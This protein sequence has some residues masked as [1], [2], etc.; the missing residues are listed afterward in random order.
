MVFQQFHLWPHMTVLD[1]LTLA[2]IKVL[3]T[4]KATAINNAMQLLERFELTHKANAM[5]NTLSGGQQQRISIARSLMMNPKIMLLD[6]P[7]SALDPTMT[8]EILKIIT[9]LKQDKM[10]ILISTHEV[11]FA[12]N[13]AD[14]VNF[15]HHGKIL[16]QGTTANLVQPETPELRQ[17]L[18]TASF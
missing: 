4:S 9:Q 3:K 17:F 16:E 1:N 11:D 2:P 18:P 7:T 8:Y 15:L 5:P 13:V 10:T 12:R 14:S 6:E